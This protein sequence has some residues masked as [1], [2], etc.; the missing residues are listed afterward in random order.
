MSFVPHAAA[1]LFLLEEEGHHPEKFLGIPLP[2][3]QLLNLVLFLGVLIYFVAKPMSAA[4]RNRQLEIE[5]R[6]REAEHRRAEVD[7]LA[8]EIEV[9]T[10]RLEREIEEIRRQGVAEGQ[11]ARAELLARAEAEA[12]R[13]RREA[14]EEIERRLAGA[15]LELRQ[16]AADLTASSAVDLVSREVT[17]ED[18]HR[19]VLES[20]SRVKATP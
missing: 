7:R 15:K 18:R 10:V 11:S 16:T 5:K 9:R 1:V 4:F 20:A 2:I 13:V 17:E 3:W 8:R 12:E 19:L 6:T 14:S